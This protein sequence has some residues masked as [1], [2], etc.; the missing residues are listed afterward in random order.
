[1]K[2]PVGRFSKLPPVWYNNDDHETRCN[3]LKGDSTKRS[4]CYRPYPVFVYLAWRTPIFQRLH[5]REVNNT[6]IN[7]LPLPPS[8]AHGPYL[9]RAC[10]IYHVVYVL[11]TV[12]KILTSK[13]P[14]A[15]LIPHSLTRTPNS[16]KNVYTTHNSLWSGWFKPFCN[17]FIPCTMNTTDATNKVHKLLI[18]FAPCRLYHLL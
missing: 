1:M 5:R 9:I 7:T 18:R 15:R 3:V 8:C 13:G 11:L 2:L 6:D 14:Y 10:V 4:T 16:K 17:A 12:V